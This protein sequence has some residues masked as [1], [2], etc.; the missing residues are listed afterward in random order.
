MGREREM[1]E[2]R[3]AQQPI[4]PSIGKMESAVP[5]RGNAETVAADDLLIPEIGG[6]STAS[7]DPAVVAPTHLRC[8]P[9][10][11]RPA[12]HFNRSAH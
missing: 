7:W 4:C 8:S 9:P 6:Q 3:L 1:K 12:S 2:G 11:S 5:R 10:E